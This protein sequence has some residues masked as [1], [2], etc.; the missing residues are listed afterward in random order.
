[1]NFE[2]RIDELEF[3]LM[4]KDYEVDCLHRLLALV[5]SLLENGLIEDEDVKYLIIDK[6]Q[7][8]IVPYYQAAL[9][10]DQFLK[11]NKPKAKK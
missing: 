9:P 6:I 2:E 11:L 5:V 8:A 1:M 3:D 10:I 7:K 4:E